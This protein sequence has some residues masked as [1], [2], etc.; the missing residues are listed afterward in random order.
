MPSLD[1]SGRDFSRFMGSLEPTGGD[2]V[3][4]KECLPQ[5]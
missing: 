1:L 3:M 5:A 4:D 2:S